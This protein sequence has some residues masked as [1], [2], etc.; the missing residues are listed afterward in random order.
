MAHEISRITSSGY[1]PPLCIT[2]VTKVLSGRNSQLIV[3]EVG[4]IQV[5]LIEEVEKEEVVAS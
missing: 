4:P 2:S 1:Q 3:D 5:G